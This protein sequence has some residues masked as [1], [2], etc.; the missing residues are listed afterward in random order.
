MEER[1][2]GDNPAALAP[3]PLME[4]HSPPLE[5]ARLPARS[6]ALA[7]VGAALLAVVVSVTWRL[8]SPHPNPVRAGKTTLLRCLAG[9]TRCAGDVRLDGRPTGFAAHRPGLAYLPQHTDLPEWA[10]GAEVLDL[11]GRLRGA[12][13]APGGLPPGFLPDL[14]GRVGTLSGGQSSG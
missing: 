1:L 11:F 7:A 5:P 10:T 8:R 14:H 13:P 3:A 12:R 9:L 6:G 2:V 4:P